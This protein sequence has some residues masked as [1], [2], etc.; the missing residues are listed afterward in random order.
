ILRVTSFSAFSMASAASLVACSTLTLLKS[1][2]CSVAEY[3]WF[4]LSVDDWGPPNATLTLQIPGCRPARPP[5]GSGCLGLAVLLHRTKHIVGTEK[6]EV[7][8]FLCIAP[9]SG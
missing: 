5:V 1:A 8:G 2:N 4:P 6:G 7:K 3:M 9:I